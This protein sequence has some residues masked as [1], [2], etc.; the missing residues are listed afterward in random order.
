[1]SYKKIVFWIMLIFFTS[2]ISLA[3]GSSGSTSRN[4][5][6]GVQYKP[7]RH[8]LSN[9]IIK[10]TSKDTVAV[11]ALKKDTSSSNGSTLDNIKNNNNFTVNYDPHYRNNISGLSGTLG[12]YYNNNFRI[13]SEVSHEI[14]HI[15]NDGYK[16]VGFEKHFALA[17]E[18]AL[19]NELQEVYPKENSYVTITNNGV[20]IT[21]L[22]INA[23]YD[24][25]SINKNN[26]TIY[27]CIGF[28]VDVIDFLSKY[29]AKL[30]YQG[31]I[32]ASYPIFSKITLF[33]EGYYHG[34]LGKEFNNIPVNYPCETNTTSSRTTASAML[35]VRYYGGSIGVR[36]IL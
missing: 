27:S 24:N 6:I 36:F 5:Y 11:F 9:F 18:F 34:L 14:F 22:L 19:V 29:N 23:C 7:A 26:I 33:A 21:S 20:E 32:G 4:L 10:E 13:E 25:I 35:N 28:G 8:H 17:R 31:K 3:Q 2:H 30:S 12:Y 1:M 15:K 16:V